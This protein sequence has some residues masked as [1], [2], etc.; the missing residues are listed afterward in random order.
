MAISSNRMDLRRLP[1]P[2]LLIAAIP[3]MCARAAAKGEG[4]F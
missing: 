1:A 2:L 3:A 4:E